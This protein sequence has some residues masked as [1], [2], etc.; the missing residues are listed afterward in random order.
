M[1]FHVFEWHLL[2]NYFD[3]FSDVTPDCDSSIP[4]VAQEL[5]KKMIHQFAVEYASKCTKVNYISRASS[6]SSEAS[7]APLD[8]TVSRT[9]EEKEDQPE[10]GKETPIN[11]A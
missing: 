3:V 7:D 9:Q 4:L 2:F 1:I 5:M 8:L 6:P 10:I 11:F